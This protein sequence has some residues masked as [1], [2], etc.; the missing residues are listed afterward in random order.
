MFIPFF[1]NFFYF[2]FAIFLA[3]YIPGAIV[4]GNILKKYQS[5]FDKLIINLIVGL[6]LWVFQG[7]I[8]GYL[9]LRFFSYLYLLIFFVVWIKGKSSN[10]FFALFRDIKKIKLNYLLLSIFLLGIFGQVQQFFI[11]GFI[12]PAGLYVFTPSSDDAFWHTALTSEL[13][14]RFPPIEPGLANV[15]VRNYH[16]LSN[17]VVAEIIRVF[18]LPLLATQFQF[19][20]L[21]VSFL[22]GGVAYVLGKSFKF[23]KAALTIFVFLQY[24]SSDL[25]YLLTFLTKRI[26]DFTIHPLEDGTM[27]LE[28][29]PRAFSFVVLFCGIIFLNNFFKSRNLKEGVIMSFLFGSLIGFKVHTGIPILLA[30]VVL[31][32]YFVFKKDWKVIFLFFLAG[33]I[34]LLIYL[35]VNSK[36]GFPIIAPFEMSRMFA[37]QPGLHISFFELARRI[38]NDHLNFIQ[39]LRMDLTML[40]IFLVSQFGIRVLGFLP[41][42]RV[43]YNF[44]FALTLF[45]YSSIIISILFGTLFIQPIAYADIFNIYLTASLL[46]SILAAF[47]I[48]SLFSNKNIFLKIVVVV[49]ILFVT[50]PRWIYKTQTFA[51]YFNFSSVSPVISSKELQAMEFLRTNSSKGDVVLVFNL[52]QWDSMFP[53]VSTFTKKDMFLSGKSILGRHGIAFKERE[54]IVEKISLSNNEK[55]IKNILNENKIDFLYFYGKPQLKIN[56]FTIGAEII[57]NNGSISIYHLK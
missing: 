7:L 39:T 36:S 41:L 56:L 55:E 53:Y 1:L 38:Y 23:S 18:N 57:F 17:F 6:I 12:F 25:I 48:G 22:L 14:Q 8:F 24:F 47:V 54:K 51:T 40:V 29:P 21:L 10:D 34:S 15:V 4:N 27:F 42:K 49:I 5:N 35:P 20:Y 32:F 33:V 19:M 31:G 3:F 45:L 13:V 30:L 16:Y 44:G 46:L 43:F 9:N 2:L 52:G 50:V 37:V 26:F 11:T 28:N